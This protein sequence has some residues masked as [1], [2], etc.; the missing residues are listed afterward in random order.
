MDG[1]EAGM[2]KKKRIEQNINKSAKC[3]IDKTQEKTQVNFAGFERFKT[4]SE[5]PSRQ[6]YNIRNV[7]SFSLFNKNYY[8]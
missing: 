4:D 3:D 1:T 8:Y 2:K 7:N 5:F 6:L